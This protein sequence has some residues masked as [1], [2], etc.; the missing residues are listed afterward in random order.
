MRDRSLWPFLIAALGAW[1]LHA[2][3]AANAAPRPIVLNG[4][5][6]GKP[7]DGIGVVDGGGGTSVLLKDYPEPQRSQI[8]DLLYKP[9]FG[10]AVSALYVEIPGDGNSTQGSMPSHMHTREDLNYSRGYTWWVMQ[11]ARKRNPRLSLDGTAW[12]APGWIGGKGTLFEQNTGKEYRG[13]KN[14]FSQDTV[15][16]YVK[17]LNGLRDV[18]GMELD[19]IGMRNEKG[20][21]YGLIKALRAGLNANG[22]ARVKVHAFDNW[23]DAWKF[24]F[25]KDMQNDAAL[26]DAIDI[27]GAHINVPKSAVPPEVIEA[28]RQMGKPIWNTEQHVYKAGYDGLIGIVEAINKNYVRSGITKAVLWYGI[29]G[30]YTMEPYSGEKEATLRANWPWSGHYSINPSLWAYAHYGQFSEIGWT[31][32]DGGSGE[33]ASGGTYVTLKSPGQDYSMIVETKDATG[34]QQLRFDVGAGLSRGALAVWRS[35]AKQHFVRQADVVPV[36][37]VVTLQLD[38]ESVYSITS[39]R[40]QRKGSF[41]K[42]PALKAFPFPYRET[43]EQYVRPEQWGYLPRYFADIAGAFELAACPGAKGRCLRQA[44]PVPTISWAPDWQPYTI[45]GDDRWSD[46]EVSVDVYLHAGDAAGVM[47]R[48]NHVGTGYGIIPKGYF[49]QLSADGQLKLVV[50]R[51]KADKK[52]LVGDS[53]QQALIRAQND[54]SVGGEKVLATAR[55]GRVAPGQWHT[56]KLGFKGSRI[57]AYVD[58]KAALSVTDDLYRTG[59]AG[60]MAGADK[61]RMSTPYFDNVVVNRLNGSVPAIS[62]PLRGQG[63]VYP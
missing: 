61:E 28:A 55:V 6:G 31:Y 17:W 45:I 32:L 10:A 1:P 33:L 40:G 34:A 46:Y 29:A 27:I 18:Y 8:L 11:E 36:D 58:G 59:M 14:F 12:S 51:G 23:P 20:V 56:L 41:D 3:V 42:I 54:L 26:R 24:N 57:T 60:L 2:A 16:Y 52:A 30:L 15:D 62:G 13:D 48:I 47:G 50:V 21:S 5:A 35:N 49:A 53:E 39:T 19:A 38:P 63:P 4:E 37:G 44:A 9:R 25:V 43:F 22:F 7:F